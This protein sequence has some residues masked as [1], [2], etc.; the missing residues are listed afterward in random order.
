MYSIVKNESAFDAID[1][2]YTSSDNQGDVIDELEYDQPPMIQFQ[3]LK[4]AL[5][6]IGTGFEFGTK[7]YY[8]IQNT[9]YYDIYV[10]SRTIINYHKERRHYDI[11]V[12]SSSSGC[13]CTRCRG[14]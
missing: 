1:R 3:Y 4:S 10:Y 11:P 2:L 7:Y 13:L 14:K 6:K 12:N 9:V 5:E 8:D